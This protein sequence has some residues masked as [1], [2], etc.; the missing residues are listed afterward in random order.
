CPDLQQDTNPHH[1]T[2]QPLRIASTILRLKGLFHWNKPR[3]RS[4]ESSMRVELRSEAQEDLVEGAAFYETQREGLGD[5]FIEDLFSELSDLQHQAG[6][7]PIVFGLHR[8]LSHRFPFAIYYQIQ[9]S[10]VVD[11]IAIL[12]CRGNPKAT[13]RRLRDNRPS[14]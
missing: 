2:K 7:H 11:V 8:K 13:E 12:D 10:E 5:E 1:G 9:K 3:K 4:R 6:I 14:E